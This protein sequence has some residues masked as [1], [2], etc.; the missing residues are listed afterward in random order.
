MREFA[1]PAL[2]GLINIGEPM[3]RFPYQQTNYLRAAGFG[4]RN[5]IAAHVLKIAASYAAPTTHPLPLA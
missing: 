4:G 3:S 2:R 1:Q 5:R